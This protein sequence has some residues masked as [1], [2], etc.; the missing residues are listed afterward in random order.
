[1]S[2]KTKADNKL[3]KIN[4]KRALVI[5]VSAAVVIYFGGTLI[6]QQRTLNQKNNEIE[7]LEQKI[8]EAAAETERLKT[9]VENLEN[10]EYIEKI[11]RERLGLIGPN[12]RVF[13]DANKAD[14]TP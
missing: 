3:K 6:S 12:E 11:A 7:A 9:E 10:P 13:V 1:M 2:R 4:I 8:A 5:F 14:K